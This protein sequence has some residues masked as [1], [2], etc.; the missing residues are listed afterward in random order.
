MW[1]NV[2]LLLVA[3]LLCTGLAFAQSTPLKN[4][5]QPPAGST[6][7]QTK[8]LFFAGAVVALSGSQITVA[9][10]VAETSH[11]QRT[12]RI[13]PQTKISKAVQV[14]SHVTVHYEHT[15]RGDIAIEIQVRPIIHTKGT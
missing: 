1:R 4:S 7:P 6:E 14:K 3:A 13:T 9:R 2:V 15:R 11:E 10:E 12:F 8:G 5:N